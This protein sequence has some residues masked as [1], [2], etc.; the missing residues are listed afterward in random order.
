MEMNLRVHR[1]LGHPILPT[2]NILTSVPNNCVSCKW[3]AVCLPGLIV[4]SLGGT[5][6]ANSSI[7]EKYEWYQ[8]FSIKDGKELGLLYA[9]ERRNHKITQD[10]LELEKMNSEEITRLDN[11]KI[12]DFLVTQ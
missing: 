3:L 9:E 10:A 2:A 6:E 12:N 11:T 1:F 7:R 5:F 4:P 8:D